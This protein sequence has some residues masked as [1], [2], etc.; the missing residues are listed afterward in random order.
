M[1]LPSP[2]K[3]DNKDDFIDDCMDNGV[4]KKEFTDTD[5]RYAVCNRIWDNK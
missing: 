5:R 2:T 1:P 3:F 4:M